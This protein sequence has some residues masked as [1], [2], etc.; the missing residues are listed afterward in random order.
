MFLGK[1]INFTI[2]ENS[3]RMGLFLFFGREQRILKTFNFNGAQLTAFCSAISENGAQE[4]KIP[5]II[6]EVVFGR[7]KL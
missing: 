2:F 1:K 6:F 4:A 7:D 5:K 3:G